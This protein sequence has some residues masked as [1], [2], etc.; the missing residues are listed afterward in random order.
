MELSQLWLSK[1]TRKQLNIYTNITPANITRWTQTFRTIVTQ[2]IQICETKIGG[3]D[4]IVEIDES[5]FYKNCQN[6]SEQLWVFEGIERTPK[7]QIF[8]IICKD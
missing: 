8:A 1:A 6:K 7:K 2:E 5:L 3:P 4:I